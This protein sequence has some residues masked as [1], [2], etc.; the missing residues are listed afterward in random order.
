[1]LDIIAEV[2]GWVATILRASGMLAKKPLVVK[3]LVSGGNA[4]W[5]AKWHYEGQYA[6]HRQQRN[7]LSDYGG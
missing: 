6:T 3:L 4:L 1:M 5:L 7:L 2:A